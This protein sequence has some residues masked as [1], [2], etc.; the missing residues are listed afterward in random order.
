MLPHLYLIFSSNL[1]WTVLWKTVRGSNKY[2]IPSHCIVANNNINYLSISVLLQNA[3]ALF[4]W[5]NQRSQCFCSVFCNNNQ[6]MFVSQSK[7]S[8]SMRI[9]VNITASMHA[10][11]KNMCYCTVLYKI[12]FHTHITQ[13]HTQRLRGLR[14]SKSGKTDGR[15]WAEYVTSKNRSDHRSGEIRQVCW[16]SPWIVYQFCFIVGTISSIACAERM[17]I[18]SR[19]FPLPMLTYVWCGPVITANFPGYCG[20]W[21]HS[22]LDVAA[23]AIIV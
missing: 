9:Y 22:V 6:C 4:I 20:Y 8:W 5:A 16:K 12:I 11:N 18:F 15:T 23:L 19:L 10:S 21:V 14:N 2:W 13:A 1:S 3:F 7:R 17:E